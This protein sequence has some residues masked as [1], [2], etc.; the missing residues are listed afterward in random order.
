MTEYVLGQ[1]MVQQFFDAA[2]L[3]LSAGSIEFYIWDTST[4]TPVYSDSTGTSVGTSVALNTAGRPKNTGGTA[5]QLFFDPNVIYKMIL[6]DSSG[7]EVSPTSGPYYPSRAT[8]T[9]SSATVAT[10][11]SLSNLSSGDVVIVRGHSADGVGGGVF[12]YV[13]GASAGTYTDDNVLTI[14][15]TGGDGSAAF[16]KLSDGTVSLSDAGCSMDGSTDET[17]KAQAAIDAIPT[18]GALYIPDG[19]CLTRTL[20]VG[21]GVHRIFGPGALKQ[22][23]VGEPTLQVTNSARLCIDAIELIG[24]SA[25]G[26]IS[27][28]PSN[29]IDIT[30]SINVIVR[31]CKISKYAFYPIYFE[32]SIE[33]IA[34]SNTIDLSGH[35]IRL[36]AAT[37]CSV[38]GN[39]IR[40]TMFQ[41][42]E[43]SIA[44]G[45]DS[46]QGHAFGV[47]RKCVVIGNIIEDFEYGQA[48]MC[49][50]MDGGI[51]SNNI[52]TN[53]SN[54][55]GVSP[56]N[57]ND[58]TRDLNISGNVFFGTDSATWATSSPSDA[59]DG[60]F[61]TSTSSF[62]TPINISICNNVIEGFNTVVDQ[63]NQGGIRVGYS[64]NV[65]VIGNTVR[66][67]R[68]NGIV[69]PDRAIGCVIGNN[70]IQDT[71]FNNAA[72]Q[73]NGI[74]VNHANADVC[75]LGNFISNI[76]GANSY[77]IR[78]DAGSVK[79]GKDNN[80]YNVDT[81]IFVDSSATCE[82]DR[83]KTVTV[84]GSWAKIDF[85]DVDVVRLQN[86]S[87]SSQTLLAGGG[88]FSN[89]IKN[90]IYTL[91][92]VGAN[93]AVIQ[94]SATYALLDGGANATLSANDCM[95]VIGLDS[96]KV[97]QLTPVSVNS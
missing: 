28:D 91:V 69:V 6:K 8:K 58:L 46:T 50:S 57:A 53:V 85:G 64:E 12:Y 80:Y 78:V 15:P 93:D 86:D 92:S 44:I 30:G 10:M 75:V 14:L 38:I 73:K 32:N 17:S 5:V 55:I 49:H 89:V 47:N 33:C 84:D 11:K 65:S 7:A 94:R 76:T 41:D 81:T 88:M 4:P 31:N 21:S 1:P 62:P 59:D 97:R 95:M 83:T 43:L 9:T 34:I 60:I 36:R 25:D 45:L 29:G 71:L 24:G 23:T 52:G 3:P 18:G 79:I 35:G 96:N 16:I 54:G 37:R 67:C 87:G 22:D 26:D 77:G 42:N 56:F 68:N 2:G 48:V 39:I 90:K 19:T 40:N 61:V 13:S 63:I 51:I 70:V 82:A 27:N 66:S 72:N 74:K 20:N